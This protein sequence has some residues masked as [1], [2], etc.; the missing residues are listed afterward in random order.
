MRIG[1]V[2][3]EIFIC[4]KICAGMSIFEGARERV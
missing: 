4:H 2:P 3:V 1:A